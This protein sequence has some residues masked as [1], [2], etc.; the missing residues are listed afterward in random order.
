MRRLLF[1]LAD[2]RQRPALAALLAYKYSITLAGI[3][4]AHVLLVGVIGERTVLFAPLIL[5]FLYFG[6]FLLMADQ[7]ALCRATMGVGL[8]AL[9]ATMASAVLGGTTLLVLALGGHAVFLVLLI[10]MILGRLF[11]ERRMPLDSV[12]AGVI[13]FLLMAGL[14]TQFYGLTVLADPQAFSA[15]DESLRHRPYATLYYLSVTSLTTAGF[16][17]VA[18]VSDMARILVAYEALVGQVYLV[19]FI[20]LLM[21]RHFAGHLAAPPESRDPSLQDRRALRR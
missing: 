9:A 20:A 12:M 10:A 11:R 16:G 19:V 1:P 3:L 7:S 8:A 4:V 17:D 13:V 5:L 14:W 15:P 18:P 6:G 2:L 21:G